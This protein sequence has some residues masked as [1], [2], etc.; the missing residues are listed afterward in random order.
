MLAEELS[1][2]PALCKVDVGGAEPRSGWLTM[3]KQP[4][5]SRCG[6]LPNSL[7]RAV[8]HLP[9]SLLQPHIQKR[10]PAD[11]P[12]SWNRHLS[13]PGLVRGF[14]PGFDWSCDVLEGTCPVLLLGRRGVWIPAPLI[15]PHL[16][17]T[18][19][20]EGTEVSLG[21]NLQTAN[22]VG[23]G[24]KSKAN[25]WGTRGFVTQ[26]NGPSPSLL[27]ATHAAGGRRLCEAPWQ[28]AAQ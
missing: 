25:P 14:H 19:G 4:P 9:P 23:R 28:G 26:G 13:D 11:L 5:G 1:S 22:S 8:H 20:Q 7:G 24:S 3:R 10:N 2:Q 12:S 6:G 18:A 15:L 21:R 16:M 27:F 17:E